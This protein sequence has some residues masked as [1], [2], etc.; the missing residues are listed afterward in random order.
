[1]IWFAAGTAFGDSPYQLVVIV[2][3]AVKPQAFATTVPGVALFGSEIIPAAVLVLVNAFAAIP[4]VSEHVT[5]LAV[6]IPSSQL[7]LAA[8][9]ALDALMM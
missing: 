2:A 3:G 8:A 1:M 4:P 6:V 7:E 9:D 5:V